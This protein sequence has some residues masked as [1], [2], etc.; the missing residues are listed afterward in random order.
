MGTEA[1]ANFLI[2]IPD[3]IGLD[4]EIAAVMDWLMRQST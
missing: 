2:G 1:P 4:E 3:Y